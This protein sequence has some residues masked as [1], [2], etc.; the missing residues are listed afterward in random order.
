MRALRNQLCV[1]VWSLDFVSDE[2]NH[3]QRFRALTVV[4]V[5][6]REALAIDVG[7]RLRGEDVVETLNRLVTQRGKP[8]YLFADNGA[9]FTGRLMDM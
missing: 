5:Y 7:V 6:T 8:K 9:E 3:G 2:L 1:H 4:D